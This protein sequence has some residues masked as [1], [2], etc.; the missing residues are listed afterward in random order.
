MGTT[1][2]VLYSSY[3]Y[4]SLCHMVQCIWYPFIWWH[5]PKIAYLIF[6][7]DWKY[8]YDPHGSLE[9]SPYSTQ[10]YDSQ[11]CGYSGQL[12]RKTSDKVSVIGRRF[13]AGW[14]A[15][16]C[17]CTSTPKPKVNYS[18][19]KQVTKNG[20][21]SRSPVLPLEVQVIYWSLP[22]LVTC[23]ASL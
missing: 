21:T 16:H 18:D 7:A 22:F 11:I 15:W 9:T 4:C 6:L 3:I 8:M 17:R 2:I 20:K 10:G 1:V 5:L 19:A 14:L 12:H 13:T 23:F